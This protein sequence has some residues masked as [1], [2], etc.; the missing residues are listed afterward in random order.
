MADDAAIGQNGQTSTSM[1]ALSRPII[2]DGKQ[3]AMIGQ[4]IQGKIVPLARRNQR[5]YYQIVGGRR[6]NADEP[7][8]YE[9]RVSRVIV[10]VVLTGRRV[11]LQTKTRFTRCAVRA[12]VHGFPR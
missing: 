9:I 11:P 5:T 10:V 6:P 3:M 1:V 4:R 2:N 8:D 7:S 12:M